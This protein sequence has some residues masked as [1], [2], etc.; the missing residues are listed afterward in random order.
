MSQLTEYH[1]RVICDVTLVYRCGWPLFMRVF[2]RVFVRASGAISRCFVVT[3]YKKVTL[4]D[5]TYITGR[6]ISVASGGNVNTI[7]CL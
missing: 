7:D 5:N 2:M 4:P 3:D 1:Q 6:K